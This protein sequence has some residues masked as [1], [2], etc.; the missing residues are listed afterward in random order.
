MCG[1]CV[2]MRVSGV[3]VSVMGVRRVWG[4]SARGETRAGRSCKND[5]QKPCVCIKCRK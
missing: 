2:C 4:N 3:V 1:E 5:Y